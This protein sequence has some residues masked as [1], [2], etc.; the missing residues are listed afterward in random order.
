M[1]QVL[2]KYISNMTILDKQSEKHNFQVLSEIKTL[3]KV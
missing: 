1:T 2:Q 3:K